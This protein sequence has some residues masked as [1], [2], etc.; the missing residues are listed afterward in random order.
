[1]SENGFNEAIKVAIQ[2]AR[3]LLPEAKNFTLEQI[4]I[5]EDG[6]NYEVTLSYIIPRAKDKEMNSQ[7]KIN[8]LFKRIM[9]EQKLYRVFLVNAETLRFRGFRMIRDSD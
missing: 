2:G 9:A 4:L 6:K 1:M 5:S 7:L 8:P 3:Q